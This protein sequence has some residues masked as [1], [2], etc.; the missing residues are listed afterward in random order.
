MTLKLATK[1]GEVVF[2]TIPKVLNAW[3]KKTKQWCLVY[4]CEYD[5]NVKKKPAHLCYRADD[6]NE[7]WVDLSHFDRFEAYP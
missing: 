6:E 5:L 2:A 7:T 3:H 1:A 4:L